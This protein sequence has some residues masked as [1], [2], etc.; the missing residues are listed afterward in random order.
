M[1]WPVEGVLHVWL[2]ALVMAA[3]APW[4]VQAFA[5]ALER[6]VRRETE[7]AL[8]AAREHRTTAKDVER[9]EGGEP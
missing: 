4:C 9:V 6:R 5:R 3:L 7:A 1:E 2:F 8:A